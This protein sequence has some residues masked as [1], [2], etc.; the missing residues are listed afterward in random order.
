MKCAS[1]LCVLTLALHGCTSVTPPNNPKLHDGRWGRYNAL[2]AE[3]CALDAM[4]K[5]INAVEIT[6]LFNDCLFDKGLT[7]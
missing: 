4:V 1:V 5:G 3:Q 7:I 2:V 6:K